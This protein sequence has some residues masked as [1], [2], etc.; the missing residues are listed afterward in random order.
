[1]IRAIIFVILGFVAGYLANHFRRVMK[2]KKL[3]DPSYPYLSAHHRSFDQ[4]WRAALDNPGAVLEN[5]NRI[6]GSHD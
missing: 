5:Y 6:F 2:V 1:M 3:N 4:G